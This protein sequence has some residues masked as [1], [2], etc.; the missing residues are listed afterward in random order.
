MNSKLE[1]NVG[2]AVD[3]VDGRLK[4]TGLAKYAAEYPKDNLAHAFL[5]QSTISSGKIKSIDSSRAEAVTGVIAVI[6]YKNAPKLPPKNNANF[7]DSLHLLQSN[8]IFHDRQ[9]IGVV[10]AETLETARYAAS[11]LQVEYSK[12]AVDVDLAKNLSKAKYAEGKKNSLKTRGDFQNGLASADVKIES[13]YVTPA[14]MHSMMEPHATTA[15]WD[16]NNL[17]IWESTQAIFNTRNKVAKAFGLAAAK[18]RVSTEFLGGGFGS[19]LEC[20]SGT[21]LAVLAAKMTQR[22]VRLA[23]TR[24]QTYGNTGNRPQTVQ[25]LIY[26]ADKKG[27]L[28]AIK[29]ECISENCRF[30]DFSEDGS[31]VSTHLY[32]CPNVVTESKVVALDIS[33]PIWMRAPG[34]CPGMYAVECAM[35]EL[36]H[37]LKMD[38]LEIRLLNYSEKDESCDLPWSSK[39]LKQCYEQGAKLFGWNER[40]LEPSSMKYHNKLVG[41]GMSSAMHGAYRMEAGAKLV[42]KEDGSVTISSGTQD[43]G[44]GTYTIMTQIAADALGLPLEKVRFELGDTNMPEAPLSGGSMTAATAGSA[45]HGI[46]HNAIEKLKEFLVQEKGTIFSDANKGE[47]CARNEG[48]YLASQEG[49]GES[50]VSILKR[51]PE[52]QLLVEA[53]FSPDSKQLDKYS[54]YSFGAHFAEVMV[55]AELGIVRVTR[56]V[57]AISAGKIIN[58]KTAANQIKGGVIFGIGMALT[59]ALLRD[60]KTGRTINADLGEYHLPVHADIPN[61]EVVFV[62]E[63]DD[64]VNPLGVKGVGEI[65]V[66]GVA[67]AIANAIFHATGKRVR[68]L[69]ITLDKLLT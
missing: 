4:V 27:K 25:N 65:A 51:L 2:K 46:C 59:E 66:I 41:W 56:F 1:K 17:H 21:I 44:T 16:G 3:R 36:A 57:S 19:K 61:I 60:E 15:E 39:S 58:P 45:V 38:P 12:K 31:T 13:T 18:V 8:E 35:D 14:E 48:I 10:V 24:E 30:T 53:K 49:K 42:L 5:V 67:A 28:T 50:Y 32:S 20:W 64:V 26:A 47:L 33:K 23:L 22:P 9:N 68:E 7:D 29:H 62:D 43:I 52:K 54:K 6:T 34:D 37:T 40:K 11:L 69:P 55:D 63:K